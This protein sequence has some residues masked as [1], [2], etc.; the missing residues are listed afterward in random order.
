MDEKDLYI[1]PTVLRGM[2]EEMEVMQEEIFGPVLPVVEFGAVDEVPEIVGK[3]P[4]PLAFYIMS[5]RKRNVSR[6]LK[7]TTSGGV[8][9]NDLMVGSINPTLPF[10]GINNSG[11]GKS[12]GRHGFI[13]FSNERGIVARKWGTLAFVRPPF[14]SRMTNILKSIFKWF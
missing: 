11:I 2:T 5:K 1:A 7:G 4:Q 12:N 8:V 10:G 13:E 14:S 3:R 6:I 9:L